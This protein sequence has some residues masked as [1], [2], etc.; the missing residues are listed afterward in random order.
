MAFDKKRPSL[1]MKSA[2]WLPVWLI[3]LGLISWQ[4][5]YGGGAVLAPL[6]TNNIPFWWD[7]VTVAGWSLFIFY[8]AMY[9]K[10]SSEKMLAL[11]NAQSGIEEV[12]PG[13]IELV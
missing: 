8:W 11:V 6:N 2:V 4:G 7:I 1:D 10:L 9:T 3:G 13:G 5:Q 12:P